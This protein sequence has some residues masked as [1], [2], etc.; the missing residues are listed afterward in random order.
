[1]NV[2]AARNAMVQLAEEKLRV[3]V[4]R[5]SGN[6]FVRNIDM[7]KQVF[8]TMDTISENTEISTQTDF[9]GYEVSLP[10]Y[11]APISGIR[12]NYGADL[13]D[14]TYT[15]ELVEGCLAAGSLAFSGDGMYDEMFCGPMDI[16]AEHQGYGIPTIKPWSESDMEWRIKLA[17]EEKPLLLLRILM[18]AGLPIYETV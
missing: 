8:I 6:A 15:Q 3:P 9:F 12:L 10:V 16:I 2:G 4:G 18:P 5:G 7:L 17:K 14:L 11:A 13:D 1:M